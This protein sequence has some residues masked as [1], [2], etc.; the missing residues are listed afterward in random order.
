VRV[1]QARRL[2][3][4]H[5]AGDGDGDPG[6]LPG[7]SADFESLRWFALPWACLTDAPGDPVTP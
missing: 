1:D 2:L 5:P 4:A 7:L 6:A 3:A